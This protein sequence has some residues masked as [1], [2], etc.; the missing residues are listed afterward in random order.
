MPRQRVFSP[1]WPLSTSCQRYEGKI[2]S[3]VKIDFC[4][5]SRENDRFKK[6]GMND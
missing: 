6:G 5:F 2:I 4:F 3:S 1:R